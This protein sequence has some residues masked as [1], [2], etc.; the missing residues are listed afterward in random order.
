MS[1]MLPKNEQSKEV[2]FSHLTLITAFALP[3]NTWRQGNCIYAVELLCQ[4]S[5]AE[6]I[7]WLLVTS[8]PP[9]L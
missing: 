5:A 7:Q 3:G 9:V 6:Y 4:T 1:K 2:G 8:V